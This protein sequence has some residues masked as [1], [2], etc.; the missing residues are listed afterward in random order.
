MYG[1][2]F[3]NIGIAATISA[4]IVLGMSP[5]LKKWMHEDKD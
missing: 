3:G 4:V 5:F 2:V 1:G